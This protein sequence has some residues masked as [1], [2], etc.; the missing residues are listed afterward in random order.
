MNRT[1]NV[2]RARLRPSGFTLIE[3]LVVIAVIAILA[4]L[5][6][7]A[8]SKA[9]EKARQIQC[10]NDERQITLSFRLAVDED[11]GASLD[12]P[13][14]EDWYIDRIGLPAEGW[15]CPTAPLREGRQPPNPNSNNPNYTG[16]VHWA[17]RVTNWDQWIH[18]V[19]RQHNR[20]VAPRAR[21]GSY[22]VNLWLFWAAQPAKPYVENPITRLF[23]KVE[24][25]VHVPVLT[26]VLVDSIILEVLPEARDQPPG[27]LF[28]GG[29][30]ANGGLLQSIV[31]R[32]GRRPSK[33]AGLWPANQPLPGA[34]NVG[35]FDGHAEQVQ[36]EK[37]WHLYWHR[38]YEPP[39]KRPGLP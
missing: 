34:V 27:D 36:M 10:L 2:V 20:P 31:P 29:D 17:W 32:H 9:R 23:F 25:Q 5:L 14:I 11:A 3:L 1:G 19:P 4:A 37:L 13:A 18:S 24:S 12:E 16:S 6:L 15:I 28:Y 30:I 22:A 8:L 26:P 21:A 39:T 33:L 38:N 35:F 7:P